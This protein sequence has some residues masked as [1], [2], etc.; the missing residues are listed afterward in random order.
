M[1]RVA[2]WA[3][4]AISCTGGHSATPGDAPGPIDARIVTD[5]GPNDGPI[6][7]PIDAAPG[8]A[9]Q[10]EFL[11]QPS[12]AG[13]NA[14]VEPPVEVAAL[15]S[16]G[17][18][19]SSATGL[20]YLTRT[21]AGVFVA[22]AG[23]AVFQNGVA[24]FPNLTIGTA[25]EYQ[26]VATAGLL[27]VT[28]V[29]FDITSTPS[30]TKSTLVLT[31]G[32]VPA[33][34]VTPISAVATARDDAGYAMPGQPVTVTL[35]G[36]GADVFPTHGTTNA[37][38]QFITTLRSTTVGPAVATATLGASPDSI[39]LTAD[40]LFTTAPCTLLLPGLPTNMIG[41]TPAAVATGDFDGDGRLDLV[42][43]GSQNL[44]IY[45]GMG[46]GRLYPPHVYPTIDG[47][48][49]AVADFNGDGHP[50]IAVISDDDS[51][52]VHVNTGGGDMT[53]SAAFTIADGA[54]WP[55]RVYS[56]A[57]SDLDGNGTTDLVLDTGESIIV[58]PGNGD[59]TFAPYTFYRLGGTSS[60]RSTA[61]VMVDIDGDGRKDVIGTTSFG[62]LY[63]LLANA[64][65][66]L[67]PAIT[68]PSSYYAGP[69]GVADYDGDGKLDVV[70]GGQTAMYIARGHGDGTFAPEVAFSGDTGSRG[71]LALDLDGDGRMDAIAGTTTTPA[72]VRVYFGNGDGTFRAPISYGTIGVVGALAAGDFDRDG[73]IDLAVGESWAIT[74]AIDE[75]TVMLG[76]GAGGLASSPYIGDVHDATRAHFA[77]IAG[78][79]DANGTVDLVAQNV[80]SS[81]WGVQLVGADGSLTAAP[82]V[83][84]SGAVQTVG[85]FDGDGRLDLVIGSNWL[86]GNGDGTLGAPV[87]S[88][89]PPFE[90]GVTATDIN[91]DGKLD[92]VVAG[93][94][95]SSGL[96][97][98]LGAGN[99]TFGEQMVSTMAASLVTTADLNGDGKLDLVSG[100]AAGQTLDVFLGAGD[101]TFAA[102]SHPFVDFDT[103]GVAAGD[104]DGDDIPDLVVSNYGVVTIAFLHG[105]GD[106][107]FAPEV[108]LDVG[109][110]AS[111]IAAVDM[112]GD[113]FLDIVGYGPA[114][115]VLRGHGDGTFSAPAIYEA[116][117]RSAAV[118]R[119]LDGDG[120]PDIFQPDTGAG[121]ARLHNNG[122]PL[123]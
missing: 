40:A 71:M 52:V 45:R 113:G 93:F 35:S 23:V 61:L 111:G 114:L 70:Y 15:D 3:V 68:S 32:Q 81:G 115:L 55:I 112:D 122:C 37:Q 102:T 30:A 13:V 90:N 42:L 20:V 39:Q 60:S 29:P 27:S 116:G 109:V 19:T 96:D 104:F 85:D 77:C 99:G 82:T 16:G 106:G 44:S 11:V 89:F 76:A 56:I 1:R 120:R 36:S 47:T 62:G 67:Q 58:V 105:N 91:G 79:F 65:G 25:G 53:V 78:D 73:R 66:T 12:N 121:F 4:V 72:E 46:T 123:L 64:D 86:H 21:S 84:V 101:G 6:D 98:A 28:S 18:V 14:L 59:G 75:L 97:V 95:M 69:I 31:P 100:A 49:V 94:Y 80:A 9:T 26:L 108:V 24:T 17:H 74:P 38:G 88:A 117:T 51:I 48:A 110:I 87:S 10:L 54:T 103:N 43:A 107:T 33:D 5:G 8:P 22:D 57:T 83:T 50:D 118:V 92:L 7:A 63:V 34:G 41:Q 2:L 119:D